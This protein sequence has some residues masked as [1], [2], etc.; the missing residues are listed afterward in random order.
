MKSLLE[1]KQFCHVVIDTGWGGVELRLSMMLDILKFQVH[2]TLFS[3]S[4]TSLNI[5]D[6][7]L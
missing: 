3:F 1:E 4:V 2:I 7:K 5:G 6:E